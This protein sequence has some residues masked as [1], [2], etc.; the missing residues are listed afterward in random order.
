MR[1]PPRRLM[2]L[3]LLMLALAGSVAFAA[4]GYAHRRVAGVINACAQKQTGRLRVV[5][6]PAACRRGERAVSWNV[7][8]PAGPPGPVGPPG[9]AGEQGPPGDTGPRGEVGPTGP[10]GPQGP[11]GPRLDT[12]DELNGTECHAPKGMGTLSISYSP[13][14]GAASIVCVTGGGGGS[15]DIRI[16][17][18]MTGI[19]GAAANEFVEIYNAGTADA[20]LGGYK[21]VYRSATGTSDV[22]LATIPSGTILPAGSFYLFG[23]RDYA[24]SPPA[25]QTFT[26]GL[27]S[28]GGGL[29]VRMPDGTIVDSLGYGDAAN[30]FVRGQPAPAPPAAPSPGNSDVRLPDG[31]NTDDNSADFTVTTS[32]TPRGPN[33]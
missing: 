20:D 15:V 31:H 7:Q 19:T 27:A 13:V 3:G 9:A 33:A 6:H 17:E 32:P 11:P 16:N 25:D 21:L 10:A 22:G 1:F 24:G 18:F 23:G 8:G 29:A 5:A 2:L 26:A 4:Q 12:L 14:D 28:T 30:A